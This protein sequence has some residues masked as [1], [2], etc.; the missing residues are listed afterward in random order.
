MSFDLEA[1]QEHFLEAVQTRIEQVLA[2]N[3]QPQPNSAFL[4]SAVARH[5]CLTKN[6]KRIR[7]LLTHWFGNALGVEPLKLVDAA[8]ACEL[9]HSASLLHDDV[10]DNASARR[11]SLSANA[12]W[13]N[14]VAVL[15]G[16]YVLAIAFD[17]LGSYPG[18]VTRDGI[19]TVKEMTKAAIAEIEVRSRVDTEVATWKEIAMGKTG[20]LFGLC[21]LIGARVAENQDAGARAV[22]LG[23]HI[24]M[25]FQMNDDII[26][27]TDASGLKD[28][29]SDIINKEPSLPLIFASEDVQFSEALKLAWEAELVGPAAA[30]RLGTWA[31]N[32]GAIDKTRLYM[33]KEVGAAIDCLGNLAYTPG[34]KKIVEWLNINK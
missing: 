2:E 24:G 23:K 33:Q 32:T 4:L 22:R 25:V 20:A 26:D 14:S 7:P 18:S 1:T 12:K 11:G 16:N 8:V 27:I 19:L 13:S 34:G 21:G 31:Q 9:I 3:D 5:L 17:L 6:A 10:V 30:S 28:R 15:S 29:Y